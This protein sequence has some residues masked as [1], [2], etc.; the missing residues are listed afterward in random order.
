VSLAK[1]LVLC[2]LLLLSACSALRMG[3]DQGPHLAWWWLDG[4]ADFS[5]EQATRAKDAI[6]QWFIWHRTTQLPQ[7][8][9]WLGG[10]QTKLGESVTPA[11]VCRWSDEVRAALEPALERALSL[12]APLAPGLGEAQLKHIEQRFAKSNDEFRSEHLQPKAEDRQQA[13]VK[14]TVERAETVYGRLDDAQRRMITAGMAASP[15]DAEAWMADRLRRQRDTLQTLRRLAEERADAPRALAALKALAERT[16]RSTDPTYRAYQQRLNEFNC[17]F[18]ARLHN[19]TSAAQR[20]AA[21]DKFKGWED[22]LRS[23][24]AAEP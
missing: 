8:A 7:H 21:R 5:G 3:Y 22:D 12:A 16:E 6:R 4:Y 18:I 10:L 11:Q 17:N 23:L 2:G 19:S 14:R 9:A 1:A 20:Q 13:S 24:A 15:F